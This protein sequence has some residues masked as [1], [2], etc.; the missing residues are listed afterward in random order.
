M[1]SRRGI[2]AGGSA[3]IIAGAA[4]RSA[5][6][7]TQADIIVIGAGLAGLIAAIELEG[8]GKRV[9]L[10][11]GSPRIGG[12]L[13]TLDDLPGA[14]EAG[15]IQ[16][17]SGYKILQD[18]AD[19]LKIGL[20]AGGNE[21]RD[22]LYR[23][24]GATI[25]QAAW[26]DS[27]ANRTTGKERD[28][29]PAGLASLY[30]REMPNFPTVQDWL[31]NHADR[32]DVSYGSWLISKGM[33]DEADRLIRANFN[34]NGLSTMSLVH[35]MRSAALFRAGAGPVFTIVGGSQRLPIA[36]AKALAATDVRLNSP[37]MAIREGRS[38]V[39]VTLANGKSLSARHCICTIPFSVLRDIPMEAALHPALKAT[40]ANLPYTRAS[41]A[42][43]EASEPFWKNDGLPHTVWTDDPLLGRVFVLGDAPPMLKVWL[44][45]P[46]ADALDAMDDASAGAA[47]IARYEAARPSAKGKLRLARLF[48]WQ[49]QPFAKGIYH[50]LGVG[51]RRDLAFASHSVGNRLRFAGE[52][53]AQTASGMEGALDSGKRVARMIAEHG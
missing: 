6:G 16:V 13:R 37:V 14:P 41:F 50:H 49:K 48:S 7:K 39:R 43:L 23:I 34:G 15:A 25:T 21:P 4:P 17:G 42:Y 38:G 33:S 12:R 45:G 11:E 44:S 40:I 10:I 3:A 1:W 20:T 8:M 46:F 26:K 19:D 35:M 5:W 30:V 32:Y 36:M 24:N 28:V 53:L 9:I 47:I 29:P 51:M 27:P 31:A 2:V 52:H 22:A 18:A